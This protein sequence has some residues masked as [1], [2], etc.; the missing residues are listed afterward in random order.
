MSPR[1]LLPLLLCL[2][3]CSVPRAT[4]T[5]RPYGVVEAVRANPWTT[6]GASVEGRPLHA[7]TCGE[8]PRIVYLIAGTH[9][10][11]RPAVL[12]AERLLLLATTDLPPEI[13][14]RL[15]ADANPDGTVA[16][17]RFN[18]RGVDLNRNWP[19]T[20][21]SPSL[22]RGPASLS[23]PESRALYWDLV[24]F[25]PDLVI[26]LHAARGG[27]YVNYDGPAREQAERMARAAERLDARWRVVSEMGYAT[28]GSLGSLIGRES[29]L[30][31]LTVELDR[32]ATAQEAWPALRAGLMAV[33]LGE[34]RATSR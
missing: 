25:D 24:A 14:L 8:G 30:P 3:A 12:N 1:T 34:A 20:N 21:F 15:L 22:R 23:E 32:R 27:P 31:I 26:V 28:P 19:A 11:E 2:A 33:L 29:G 16:E 13:T 17:R 10:D 7:V 6:I 5:L 18:A 4:G 9:G